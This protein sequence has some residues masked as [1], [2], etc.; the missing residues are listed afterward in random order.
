MK[1]D[2]LRIAT[3]LCTLKQFNILIAI[4]GVK[5]KMTEK[6]K[7]R[8]CA[9]CKA[10]K[11]QETFFNRYF[12]WRNCPYV[13]VQCGLYDKLKRASGYDIY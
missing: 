6:Q 4:K 11:H 3:R 9:K 2:L 1:Q 8:A 7:D 13:C 10:R 5:H 12:D